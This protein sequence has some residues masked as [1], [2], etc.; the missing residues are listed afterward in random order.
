MKGM[1]NLFGGLFMKNKERQVAEKKVLDELD[2]IIQSG[3]VN[4]M[5]N[6]IHTLM[7]SGVTPLP[8]QI[9]KISAHI[10]NTQSAELATE[11]G[12]EFGGFGAFNE[13]LAEIVLNEGSAEDN[14]DFAM[15]VPG[16]DILAHGKAIKKK[17]SKMWWLAFARMWP[18]EAKKILS[19]QVKATVQKHTAENSKQ[20]AEMQR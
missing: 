11:F 6:F 10:F 1:Q 15:Y 18:V 9:A 4:A 8:R 2:K 13:K 14:Y 20:N 16:A 17:R 3:D 7:E 19:S 5:L 12:V